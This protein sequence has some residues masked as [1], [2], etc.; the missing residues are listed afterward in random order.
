MGLGPSGVLSLLLMEMIWFSLTGGSWMI[1]MILIGIVRRE[2][3]DDLLAW[4]F[5]LS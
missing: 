1:I 5:G 2:R 4:A 3:D